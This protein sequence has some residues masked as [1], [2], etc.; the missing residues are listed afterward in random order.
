MWDDW[1]PHM[2]TDGTLMTMKSGNG[3]QQ[4]N[5]NQ[6]LTHESYKIEK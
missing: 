1:D 5:Y 2:R 6:W 3:P 4:V